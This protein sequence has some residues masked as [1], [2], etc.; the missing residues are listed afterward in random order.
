MLKENIQ[1]EMN[2]LKFKAYKKGPD[3]LV[4]VGMVGLVATTILAIKHYD[5]AKKT[6]NETKEK[7]DE[8]HSNKEKMEKKEYQ[9]ELF[10]AYAGA[11]V[12]V[13]KIYGPTVALGITSGG[14]ILKSH[15]ML[16]E[17]N[18]ILAAACSAID[19]KAKKY[20]NRTAAVVGEE[21][22]KNIFHGVQEEETEEVVVKPSGKE[23][24][25]KKKVKILPMEDRENSSFGCFNK[26]CRGFDPD[27]EKARMYLESMEDY[28]NKLRVKN[29]HMF[30]NEVNK[31]MGFPITYSG[32]IDGWIEK[33]I[34]F[35]I[36]DCCE[37]SVE[38]S[39][40]LEPVYLVDF[41]D[42]GNILDKIF[43]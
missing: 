14:C 21:V 31:I 7:I 9:K 8:L 41:N 11:A 15:N 2:N 1:R 42:Q 24:K 43:V 38:N 33:E 35:T 32:Q 18:M 5:E 3:I 6:I 34:H 22:E 36:T 28:C 37:R 4:F 30:V 16:K 26:N 27:P 17:R 20:R 39:S 23:K 13:S 40:I 19:D 25:E 10:N 29:G 12:K